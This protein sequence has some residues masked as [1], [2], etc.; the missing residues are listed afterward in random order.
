MQGV[1]RT[2][3]DLVELPRMKKALENPRFLTR[4]F[5]KEEQELFASRKDPLEGIAANF[6][7]KEAFSKAL[8]TGVRG[9][10]LS[11]VSVLRDELG[12]PY[13]KLSGKALEIAQKE[14]WTFSI[15]LTHTEHYASAVVVAY[16]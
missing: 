3:I 7:G 9:F 2:G 13:L 1:I 5:S 14:G 6:A 12:A 16:R 4:V 10:S 11:E 8:G 15:S